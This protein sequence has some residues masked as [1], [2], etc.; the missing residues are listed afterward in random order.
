[1]TSSQ[2]HAD[3]IVSGNYLLPGWRQEEV[4]GNGAV[5][6]KDDTII[7]IGTREEILQQYHGEKVIEEPHWSDHARPDQHPHPCTDGLFQGLC[8]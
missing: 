1:M 4:V 6:V 7:G 8:R 2:T 3:L 5:A